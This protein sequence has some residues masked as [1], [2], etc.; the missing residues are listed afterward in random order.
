M[1]LQEFMDYFENEKKLEITMLSQGVTMLYS[2]FMPK[3]K[4]DERMSKPVSEVVKI[5][6]KKE[7]DPWVRT[8]LLYYKVVRGYLACLLTLYI[9][10]VFFNWSSP[11]IFEV[12]NGLIH[13]KFFNWYPF[14]W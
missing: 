8:R 4:R 14:H 13:Y 7:I 9:Q 5:V 2:F 12:Q 6:S 11:K 10:G 3:A 1:T